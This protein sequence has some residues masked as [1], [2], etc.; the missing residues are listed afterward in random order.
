MAGKFPEEKAGWASSA[1]RTPQLCGERRGGG[2]AGR[3]ARRQRGGSH[4]AEAPVG[5]GSQ[6]LW[7]QHGLEGGS[8]VCGGD[9]EIWGRR[10]GGLPAE[11]LS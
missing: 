10:A 7:E 4:D 9:Q 8:G 3:G 5:R 2:S 11:W 6:I 1:P